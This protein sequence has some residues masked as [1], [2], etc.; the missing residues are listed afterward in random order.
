MDQAF[1]VSRAQAPGDLNADVQYLVFSHPALRLDDII[2]TA[3]VDQLHHHIKLTVIHSQRKYLHHIRMIHG[4]SDA[5]F[6]LQ[7]RSMIRF[8]TKI[9]VQ[10]F[11]RNEPFQLRVARFI[12]C[13]HPTGAKRF[14]RHKMIERSLE[15]VL[16]TAVPAGYPHQRFITARIERGTAYPTG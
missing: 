3:V 14:H 15:Q 10:Q 1:P 8:A 2:K 5:R 13:A 12:H 11:E 6:L 4:R 16:L 9:L 7:L